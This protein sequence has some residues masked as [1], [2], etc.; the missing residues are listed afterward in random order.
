MDT[1]GTRLYWYGYLLNMHASVTETATGITLN[2][3]K[4]A[5]LVYNEVKISFAETTQFKPGFKFTSKVVIT[6]GFILFLDS[7]FPV[8]IF[9]VSG[10]IR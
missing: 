7:I 6:F 10:T 4:N 3:T 1:A 9:P 8:F 5:T 2:G